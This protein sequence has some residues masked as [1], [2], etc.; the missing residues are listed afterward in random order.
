MVGFVNAST[1][2]ERLLHDSIFEFVYL[3]SSETGKEMVRVVELA[4]WSL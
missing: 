4:N 2:I 3:L 1:V